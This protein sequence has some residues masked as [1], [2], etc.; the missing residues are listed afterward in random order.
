MPGS[1]VEALKAENLANGWPMW[2]ADAPPD[3]TVGGM[4]WEG[5]WRI[6]LTLALLAAQDSERH[7]VLRG[8]QLAVL[9]GIDFVEHREHLR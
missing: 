9:V 8:V 4:A 5:R 1:I 6:R 7:L 3:I 2:K